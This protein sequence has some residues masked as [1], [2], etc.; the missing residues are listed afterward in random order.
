MAKFDN[1]KV[2]GITDPIFSLK[3]REMFCWGRVKA[4][5][6]M[7]DIEI[8][9]YW[10]WSENGFS[11]KEEFYINGFSVSTSTLDTAIVMGLDMK[12][13]GYGSNAAVYACKVLGIPIT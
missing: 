11:S 6:R 9:E 7:S 4:I 12:Y 1:V 8:I 2:L 13:N 5:H 10:P 3:E